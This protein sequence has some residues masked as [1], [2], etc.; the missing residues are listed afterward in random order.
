MAVLGE[1]RP[2]THS[3]THYIFPSF[4]RLAAWS[5]QGRAVGTPRALEIISHFYSGS[6]FSGREKD[7]F[8]S[9]CL[10][11]NNYLS[12]WGHWLPGQHPWHLQTNQ[13]ARRRRSAVASGWSSAHNWT[14]RWPEITQKWW[15]TQCSILTA[16]KDQ[17]LAAP[18]TPW[19]EMFHR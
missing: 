10:F 17:P 8:T 12:E 5:G 16:Q 19:P 18:C 13:T 7:C 11:P 2:H 1:E 14:E 6:I 9:Y 15:A 3:G 4:S